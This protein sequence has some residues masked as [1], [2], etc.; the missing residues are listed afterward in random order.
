MV[1]NRNFISTMPEGFRDLTYH[2]GEG[3]GLKGP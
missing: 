1:P 2:Y 3:R